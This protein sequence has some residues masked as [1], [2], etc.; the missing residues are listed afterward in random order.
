MNLENFADLSVELTAPTLP[1]GP[2]GLMLLKLGSL[3]Q[4][5]PLETYRFIHH[6]YGD[7]VYAPFPN[8]PCIFL[9]DPNSIAHVL[10][11]NHT[12]YLKSREYE[13]MKPLL[14]E[15][16][17]TSEGEHW[18]KMRKIMVKEFHVSKVNEFVP[19]INLKSEL[20][21]ESLSVEKEVDLSKIFMNLTLELA[22]EMFFGIKNTGDQKI[23]EKVLSFETKRISKN[24]RSAFNFP[25]YVP[26]LA[27]L[28]SRTLICELDKMVDEI[29]EN[30]SD[31]INV[32]SK[33]LTSRDNLE[34][35]H[36]R[37]E[38]VTLMLAGHETTI[39]RPTSLMFI[40]T[41]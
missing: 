11:H 20:K 2:R 38:I 32:L 7:I 35:K 17:L 6:K 37:D 19:V 22:C 27:H 9:F 1:T 3:I 18:K 15:G 25:Y 12:N 26:T 29:I 8:R 40:L 39:N 34:V 5:E 14:G 24:V 41:L 21:F 4:S 28:K 13:S 30:G 36:I 23:V 33:L 10:K 16:L 31:E